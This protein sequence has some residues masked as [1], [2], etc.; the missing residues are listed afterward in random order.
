VL[1][2]KLA[3][4]G[5]K[6]TTEVESDGHYCGTIHSLLY[7]PKID[8]ETG[9]LVGWEK[10]GYVDHGLIV[11][12][13]ASMVPREIYDDLEALGLPILAV[14]D[15]GQLAPVQGRDFNLM[16]APDLRL[17]RIHRQAEGNP[18]I[19][20]SAEVRRTGRI[21]PGFADE[22]HIKIVPSWK[23]VGQTLKDIF[24]RP[25]EDHRQTLEVLDT[26]VLCYTNKTRMKINRTARQLRFGQGVSADP[27]LGDVVVCLRNLH[28]LGI[29]NGFRGFYTSCPDVV[30]EH[31]YWIK[32]K[33]LRTTS[34]PH[35]I[36]GEIEFPQE[37]RLLTGTVSRYHFMRYY[38]IRQ[39]DDLEEFCFFPRSWPE[40]G[41]LFDFGYGLTVHKAQ[42]SQF[43]EVVL[44]YERPG[45]VSDENFRRW[46]YTAVTRASGRLTIALQEG[47]NP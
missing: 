31:W 37:D 44:I 47:I 17:E 26:A 29:Y 41:P 7:T 9:E 10:R 1:G 24:L 2:N 25:P 43:S 13:E 12:D 39:F 34:G 46:L 30:S 15:H 35:W 5:V 27:M 23:D 19:Q 16:G 8:S 14:G 22:K 32:K 6:T 33:Q 21:D 38:P 28:D 42:G 3:K 18:V 45:P 36:Y 40:V 4:R 20:L 11:V